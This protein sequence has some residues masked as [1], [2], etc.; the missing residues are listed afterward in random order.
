MAINTL[1]TIKDAL[2]DFV[3]GH[4]QL[5]R[6]EFESDDYRAPKI[7]EGNRFPMLFVAPIDVQVGRAMN[8]HKLR[9]YVYERINDDRSDVWEN[10]NDTSLLLRDIR[11]WWNDFSDSDIEILGEPNGEFLCD[12]ELDN[13]V[14]YSAD[15]EFI[16]P[17]HGRCNVPIDPIPP[18]VQTCA[19]G[20]VNVNKS[21]S[22]L[23][24]SIT[25]A[26]GG[27]EAYN[28]DDSTAQLRDTAGNLISTTQI[29]A[30]ELEVITAPNVGLDVNGINEGSYLSGSTIDLELTD[31]FALVTPFS[32]DKVGNSVTIDLP[33]PL[34]L[35]IPFIEDTTSTT[36]TVTKGSDGVITNVDLTGLTGVTFTVNAIVD[37][38]PLVIDVGDVVV[39][40]HDLTVASGEV[41]LIG[42]LVNALELILPYDFETEFLE[43]TVTSSL[44]GIIT[45]IEACELTGI[46]F[47]KN[48]I[49][50]TL[51]MTLA[52]NDVI[53]VNYDGAVVGGV[54]KLIGNYA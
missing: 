37:T 6:I 32:I 22:A 46:T 11:V 19:D 16:I 26:S 2:T 13:L 9:I 28:V 39:I 34:I 45:D 8:T 4:K 15:F 35:V 48:T 38:L 41:S 42:N 7:T 21:D 10:A 43:F 14:G 49:V 33:K 54:I 40:N 23:I 44:V 53:K 24:A 17:S 27:V 3:S 50:T 29:K 52:V 20:T 31:G 1:I 36:F 51:P 18:F 25:V 12:R 47:E 5:T 30:T